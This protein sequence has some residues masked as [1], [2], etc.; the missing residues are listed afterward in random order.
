MKTMRSAIEAGSR[1]KKMST[2]RVPMG[3][4]PACAATL[5][6]ATNADGDDARPTPND[7]T[8]CLHCTAVL[9]FDAAL[10]PALADKATLAALSPDAQAALGRAIHMVRLFQASRSST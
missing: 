8:I 5:S 9:T 6:A 3:H 4:C 7:L 10:V 1:A 2:H